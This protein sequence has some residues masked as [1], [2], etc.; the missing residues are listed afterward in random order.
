MSDATIVYLVIAGVVIAFVLNRFPVELVA[1]GSALALYFT[2]VLTAEETVAGF[3]NPITVLI[4][5]LFVVSEGLGASGITAW[6]TQ[7]LGQ[8]GG[9]SY[10]RLLV[11]TMLLAA[12]MSAFVTPNGAVATLVPIVVVLAMRVGRSPSEM[13]LPLSYA[14]FGGALLVLTGSPVNVIVAEA[15]QENGGGGFGFFE[16]AIVG[17]PLLIGTIAITVAVG[18]RLLPR[19]E[20][21]SMP[22]DFGK[23]ARTLL[24]QYSLDQPIFRLQVAQGSSLVGMT[25]DDLDLREYPH[26]TPISAQEHGVGAPVERPQLQPGDVLALRGDADSVRRFAQEHGLEVSRPLASTSEDSIFTRESGVAEV[27]IAPRSESIGQTVFPGMVTSSGDLV[28]LAVH[29]GGEER[30][31][32]TELRAGDTLLLQG[33]WDALDEGIADPTLLVVDRPGSIRRQVVPLGPQARLTIA[34]VAGMVI[35]LATGVVEPVIATLTAASALILLRVV[36]VQQAYRSIAWSV[37]VLIGAMIPLSTAMTKSGAADD[38]ASVIVD[39]VGAGNPYVLLIAL[40]VLVAAMGQVLSNTATALIVIPVA[41]AAAIDLDVSIQPV[42]MAVTVAASAS[43]LTP[44][45]TTPNLMIMEPGG[46]RFGDYW[47]YGLPLMGLYFIVAILWVPLIWR[48]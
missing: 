10:S 20:P 43:F 32:K 4:A 41:V 9:R 16:F 42:L 1:I 45:A 3:G 21:Q 22:A 48:F 13:L 39:N 47:K 24:Q 29:R 23:L 34:I 27:V 8:R 35:L 30:P 11:L 17:V 19:R 36:T 2:G 31:A 26:L 40:F 38:I 18:Q 33:S 25:R 46:Y 44:I 14:S 7:Q 37:V 6:A 12:I 28:V 5:S 15:S